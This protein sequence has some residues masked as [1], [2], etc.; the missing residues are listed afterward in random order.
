M[1][2]RDAKRENAIEKEKERGI[3]NAREI[4]IEIER[5]KERDSR[6]KGRRANLDMTFTKR[7]RMLVARVNKKRTIPRRNVPN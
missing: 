7:I 5:G 4:G 3:E 2:G 1:T 6:R